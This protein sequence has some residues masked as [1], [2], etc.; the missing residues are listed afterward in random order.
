MIKNYGIEVDVRDFDNDIVISHDIPNS[1]SPKLRT[2]LAENLHHNKWL[3]FNIKSDGI[4]GE[5]KKLINE[6]NISKYFCFDMS[7]PQ[8]LKYND[9]KLIWYSRLSDHVEE[10]SN[11]HN[12]HGIWL[13]S[14][15]ADWWS[16]ENLNEMAKKKPI[17]IVSP[18]LHG[19]KHS[20]IWQKIK[21]LGNLHNIFLCTDLPDE[22]KGFFDD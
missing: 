16:A 8:Q 1:K 10:Q 2:L 13:D 9:E 21:N 6:F 11:N 20:I 7:I 15:Y 4:S 5:L 3:A 19:R 14:F 18:E 22:A 12:S 17:A